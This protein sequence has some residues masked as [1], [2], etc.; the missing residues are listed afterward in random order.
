MSTVSAPVEQLVSTIYVSSARRRMSTDEMNE[1]L[2]IARRNNE[3]LG[4]TGMLVYRDGNFLQVLEGPAAPVDSVLA[5]IKLD[6]RHDGVITM[7]R[8]SI[9]E[10]QFAEWPLAFRDMGRVC[11]ES[12][13]EE[14]QEGA[15]LVFRLLRQFKEE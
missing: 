5:K 11:D 15:R 2:R 7:S 14:G 10:R 8:K 13:D 3:Q 12:E 9:E 1:L 4:I 6:P